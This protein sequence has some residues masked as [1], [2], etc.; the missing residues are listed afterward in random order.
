VLGF[1]H[2]L[3]FLNA[4]RFVEDT[5]RDGTGVR[6]LVRDFNR[7]R[8]GRGSKREVA[9]GPGFEGLRFS[10]S[11]AKALVPARFWR[12]QVDG[13]HRADAHRDETLHFVTGNSAPVVPAL[14]G[15]L[16]FLGWKTMMQLRIHSLLRRVRPGPCGLRSSWRSSPVRMQ[17]RFG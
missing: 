12:V 10:G 6:L 13:L 16:V 1:F 14:L 3:A 8:L 5:S 17:R 2:V 7:T 15:H 11:L 4:A 9:L